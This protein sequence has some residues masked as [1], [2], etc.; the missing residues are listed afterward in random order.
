MNRSSLLRPALASLITAV[1]TACG[2]G[3]SD[4]E[5]APP[6]P[7]ATVGLPAPT[8]LV[9][10]G[11]SIT[12]HPIS[13]AIQWNH[14]S[15]MAASDAAHDYAHLI[16]AGLGL[17]T[18]S[19]RNVALLERAETAD[20]SLIPAATSGID[21]QT[22]VVVQLGDNAVVTGSPAF[23]A[24][25]V[26]LLDAV[27]ARQS[28]ICLSTWWWDSGKD[29]MIKAQCEAHG[30]HYVYIGDI[31]PTRADVIPADEHPAIVDHPH[32]ASMAV[33]AQRVLAVF[34]RP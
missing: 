11:N 28:L 13:E 19:A 24:S 33:I 16:A 12:M 29:A 21:A 30:G 27:S 5:P 9:V 2:G 10:I 17:P 18:V 3:G 32:D 31:Y 1:L 4:A 15:G 7:P 26:A 14:A 6:A 25:Y 22:A 34:A 23:T 8:S 20:L